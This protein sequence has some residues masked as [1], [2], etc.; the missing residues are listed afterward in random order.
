MIVKFDF[1]KNIL[2]V[3]K[4]VS[5]FFLSIQLRF[6]QPIKFD[7]SRSNITVRS[8]GEKHNLVLP[9]QESDGCYCHFNYPKTRKSHFCE[10]RI[11]EDLKVVLSPTDFEIN[12]SHKN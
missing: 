8:Y 10:F 3:L 4:L 6:D 5:F 7:K 12:S 11:I 1:L 9:N 2:T